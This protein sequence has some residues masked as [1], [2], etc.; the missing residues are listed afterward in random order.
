M[1]KFYIKLIR[2][3]RRLWSW[4]PADPRV[5]PLI[6]LL[7]SQTTNSKVPTRVDG[8]AGRVLALQ[9]VED[10]IFYGLLASLAKDLRDIA[11][12]E[13]WLLQVRSIN[14]AIGVDPLAK[15]ARSWPVTALFNAQWRRANAGVVAGVAYCSGGW[16]S[17]LACWRGAREARALQNLLQQQ[18]G[19]V[20]LRIGGILVGDLINDSYLRFR[21][22]ATVDLFDPFLTRLLEQVLRDLSLAQDWFARARPAIYL[23]SYSTYIEH[24]IAVRVALARGV[25][26]RV[27][28]NLITFGKRLSRDDPYHAT[29]GSSYR[30][31]SESLTDPGPA[32]ARAQELIEQRLSGH[33]DP[34]TSYMR[35]SAYLPSDEPLPD[36]NG[37]L[38]V[39][40]HDFFDSPHIYPDLVFDDFW[41]WICFTIQTLIDS[42]ISFFVKPHPN[43]IAG[44]AELLERLKRTFPKISFL[45]TTITNRQLVDAGMKA[46]VTV[47]GTVGHELA[48]L[49]I[50]T[51]CCARHPH[52]TFNFCRTARSVD[53]YQKMLRE[54]FIMPISRDEMRRQ[55]L[56]F[57]YLHNLYGS[58]ESLGLRDSFRELWKVGSDDA[59]D[60]AALSHS[61]AALLAEPGWQAFLLELIE[62]ISVSVADN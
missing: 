46:G 15:I 45:S 52:H 22:A 56:Q 20:E 23:S 33:I 43:H 3:I 9:G 42:D 18:G 30:A 60:P 58:D 44:N 49:G 14:G 57:Y 40:L 61:F 13:P 17:P 51:I 19:L 62:D 55:A 41:Q 26:V 54:P 47:Y 16:A 10:P 32:L 34:A 11:G 29:N 12:L 27:F 8:L 37:A 53:E 36:V 39:F 1:L 4:L 31:I 6:A 5:A 7:Q 21:P 25:P 24:G 48:Y 38:I 50:P 59:A 2:G 28:G 35:Q